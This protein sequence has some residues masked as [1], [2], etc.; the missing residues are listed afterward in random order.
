M[1]YHFLSTGNQFQ[2]ATALGTVEFGSEFGYFSEKLS[3][4]SS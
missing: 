4:G 3:K 1:Y 2:I